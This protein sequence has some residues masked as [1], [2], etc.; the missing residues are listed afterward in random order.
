MRK[1]EEELNLPTR[2]PNISKILTFWFGDN[3]WQPLARF[4]LD[5]NMSIIHFTQERKDVC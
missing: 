2:F 5:S 3:V 4:E 1:M